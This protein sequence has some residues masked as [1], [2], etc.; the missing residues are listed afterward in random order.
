[1]DQARAGKTPSDRHRGMWKTSRPVGWVSVDLLLEDDQAGRRARAARRQRGAS[2]VEHR[3]ARARR[4]MTKKTV[5]FA[6]V[7]PG[8]LLVELGGPACELAGHGVGKILSHRRRVSSI[9]WLS[10]SLAPPGGY[11]RVYPISPIR[12]T[13]HRRGRAGHVRSAGEPNRKAARRPVSGHDRRVRVGLEHF[14]TPD[15]LAAKTVVRCNLVWRHSFR[16]SFSDTV[17][18]RFGTLRAAA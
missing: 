15:C 3:M 2:S 10:S 4:V 16:H 8:A 14:M 5:A 12:Q 18:C 17:M 6:Q 11:S 7:G 13:P 1:M 9:D